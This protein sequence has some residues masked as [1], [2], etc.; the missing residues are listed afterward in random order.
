MCEGLLRL[1][2]DRI[3]PA[4][5]P[6][7][8]NVD[9]DDTSSDSDTRETIKSLGASSRSKAQGQ[10]ARQVGK[11]RSITK[12][13]PSSPHEQNQSMVSS[14]SDARGGVRNPSAHVFSLTGRHL[15]RRSL[16]RAERGVREATAVRALTAWWRSKADEYRKARSRKLLAVTRIDAWV[17]KIVARRR[18]EALRFQSERSASVIQARWRRAVEVRRLAARVAACVAVQTVWR[19]WQRKRRCISR[20]VLR[21]VFTGLQSWARLTLSH[22]KNMARK[23]VLRAI[24]AAMTRQ[25]S[26]RQAAAVIVRVLETACNR[27][28][29]SRRR[30][31]RFAR[32]PC[33]LRVRLEAFA[34]ARV[35]R[36]QRG[37]ATV[38]ARAFRRS[39]TRSAIA[40]A[41]FAAHTLQLWS[42]R[43]LWRR[44]R[45]RSTVIIQQ[46]W[47]QRKIRRSLAAAQP[48]QKSAIKTVSI[49]TSTGKSIPAFPVDPWEL[50]ARDGAAVLDDT[51][52]SE[53]VTRLCPRW[54]AH[55][56]PLAGQSPASHCSPP[57]GFVEESNTWNGEKGASATPCDQWVSPATTARERWSDPDLCLTDVAAQ[58]CRSHVCEDGSSSYNE[59]HCSTSTVVTVQSAAPLSGRT[60]PRTP[61]RKQRRNDETVIDDSSGGVL[62][63][64]TIL[65]DILKRRQKVFPFKG[66]Q[67]SWSE[68]LRQNTRLKGIRH[69]AIAE[70][71]R[72]SG[73]RRATPASGDLDER[74]P[75]PPAGGMQSVDTRAQRIRSRW[76]R[77]QGVGGRVSLAVKKPPELSSQGNRRSEAAD[78]FHRGPRPLKPGR[79]SARRGEEDNFSLGWNRTAAKE[80]SAK[81]A[82]HR[83]SRVG[84]PGTRA[85]AKKSEQGGMGVLGARDGLGSRMRWKGASGGV[86][87]MLA[88]MEA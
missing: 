64:E 28:R 22:R 84:P 44:E 58:S 65:P 46:A 23:V 69:R 11:W 35:D 49:K 7:A 16:E 72:K 9:L 1:T 67:G 50:M 12:A 55:I 86:L 43:V 21:K 71:F 48:P 4:P 61:A 83:R 18:R 40:R 5:T 77:T 3:F 29:Q 78:S 87:E 6:P 59:T 79:R 76:A 73:D 37:A 45:S 2:V 74:W 39:S 54:Q 36:V 33:L 52:G 27:R 66:Y 13:P 81:G 47:R 51:S 41:A 30:L 24:I 70:G 25:T 88:F 75:Y 26:K 15:T 8:S 56:V 53:H 57:D 60:T 85:T 14:Q 10:Q 38:I 19:Q 20:Y 63:L 68:T 80:G 32:M 42:R 17:I 82:R 34:L 62:D 31:Q